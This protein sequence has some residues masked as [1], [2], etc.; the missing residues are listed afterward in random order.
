MRGPVEVGRAL[1]VSPRIAD[2]SGAGGGVPNVG[3]F[4]RNHAVRRLTMPPERADRFVDRLIAAR[5]QISVRMIRRERSDPLG[6][7]R[8]RGRQIVEHGDLVHRGAVERPR[9]RRAR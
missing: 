4:E 8:D 3:T 7:A 2:G 9:V 6:G 1:R 5:T